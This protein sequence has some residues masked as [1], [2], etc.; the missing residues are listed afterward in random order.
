ML[1]NYNNIQK[2][3]T[4]T[5]KN[6]YFLA[7]INE[8][9]QPIL[10]L[11]TNPYIF[12]LGPNYEISEKIEQMFFSFAQQIIKHFLLFLKSKREIQNEFLENAA[13]FFKCE[14]FILENQS[15]SKKTHFFLQYLPFFIRLMYFLESFHSNLLLK[16]NNAVILECNDENL[17]FPLIEISEFIDDLVVIFNQNLKNVS[18]F[19]VKYPEEKSIF[20]RIYSFISYMKILSFGKNLEECLEK[21]PNEKLEKKVQEILSKMLE[22]INLDVKSINTTLNDIEPLSIISCKTNKNIFFKFF[23]KKIT[24]EMQVLML[25]AI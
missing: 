13:I 8:I 24:K 21:F 4:V 11:A 20:L 6:P 23:R 10:D 9:A 17:L 3:Q 7:N 18:S 2:Y 5:I 12:K 16:N 19:I 1:H 14:K 15:N 25:Q 22:K